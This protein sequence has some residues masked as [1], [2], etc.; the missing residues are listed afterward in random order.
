MGYRIVIACDDAAVEYKDVLA[1]DLGSDPRVD[2]VI[3]A[4]VSKGEC[5]D[6][7]HV[8]VRAARTLRDAAGADTILYSPGAIRDD[9]ILVRSGYLKKGVMERLRAKGAVADFFSHFVDSHGVPVIP[10]VEDRVISIG[11]EALAGPGRRIMAGYGPDKALPM[12]VALA[13]G[14]A[15]AVVTDSRTA[16]AILLR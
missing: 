2:E 4:G 10:E 1:R 14:F 7:P 8:A 9:S 3:D 5:I 12:R 11:L 6:Y 15:T 13:A 16:S